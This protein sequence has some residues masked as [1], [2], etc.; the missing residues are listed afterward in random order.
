VWIDPERLFELPQC[1]LVRKGTAPVEQS[2]RAHDKI[3]G[4][5]IGRPFLLDPSTG[6]AHQF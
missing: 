2:P 5:G 6:I 3:G 4:I 1:C